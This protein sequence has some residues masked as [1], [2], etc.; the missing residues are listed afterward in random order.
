MMRFLHLCCKWY[1][2][3]INNEEY[4]LCSCLLSSLFSLLVRIFKYS[5]HDT[6]SSIRQSDTPN[7]S[8]IR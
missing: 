6:F 7:L 1:I 8:P 4:K 3:F 5:V 2:Q